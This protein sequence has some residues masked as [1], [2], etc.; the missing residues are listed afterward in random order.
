MLRSAV[1]FLFLFGATT[2]CEAAA[3]KFLWILAK[4]GN[5]QILR[6]M[7]FIAGDDGG[8][9]AVRITCIGKKLQIGIGAD[10]SIGKGEHDPVSLNAIAGETVL[11]IVGTSE[12]S[13]NWEMTASNELV[14]SIEADDPLIKLMLDQKQIVFRE[15]SGK[16]F[17]VPTSGFGSRF[18]KL[19]SA[20]T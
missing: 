11:K 13:K 12:K 15:A 17:T 4:E 5:E 9:T 19:K 18:A 7:D 2:S 16:K 10:A 1:I 20:C 8:D 6:G 14:K 3:P